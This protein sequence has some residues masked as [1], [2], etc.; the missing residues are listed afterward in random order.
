MYRA[1]TLYFIKNKL[2]ETAGKML[3]RYLK[4]I[5]IEF[6][7]S[8]I[9]LNKKNVTKGIRSL[10]VDKYVSKV[11]SKKIVRMEMVKTQKKFGI[12]NS[13]IMDGRDIGTTVFPRAPL[14]IYLTASP[15]IRAKR[16]MKDLKQLGEKVKIQALVN[17]IQERDNIDSSRS[18][19]PLSMAQDAVVIDSSNLTIDEVLE[20][21]NALLPLPCFFSCFKQ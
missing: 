11:S 17:Q 15:Y 20:Q 13:V 21:I 10:L 16:R 3:K 2:L 9:F 18:V 19:S 12:N 14:K 1:V 7:D 6:K 4:K 5:K 8:L